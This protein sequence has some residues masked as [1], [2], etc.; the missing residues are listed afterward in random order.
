M[1]VNVKKYIFQETKTADFS[2]FLVMFL[3]E[4][5]GNVSCSRSARRAAIKVRII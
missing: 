1:E 3:V 2:C 4:T 5:F